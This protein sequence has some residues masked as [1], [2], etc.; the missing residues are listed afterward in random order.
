MISNCI[1]DN[2]GLKTSVFS[3]EK[4]LLQG[5]L[6]IFLPAFFIIA[7][8]KVKKGGGVMTDS[9]KLLELAK[10]NNGIITAAMVA[11]AGISRGTLK[12]A[13][14]YKDESWADV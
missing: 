6:L 3:S 11:R 2:T 4:A 13:F 5:C 12:Y 10:Q 8:G 9:Q 1:A 14:K 7:S